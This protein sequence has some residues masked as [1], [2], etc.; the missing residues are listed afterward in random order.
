MS[1]SI[2]KY[3]GPNEA[4]RGLEALVMSRPESQFLYAQFNHVPDPNREKDC[5]FNQ[6]TFLCYK[7]HK[8]RKWNWQILCPFGPQLIL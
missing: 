2:G 3:V 6:Y 1:Q 5:L 8:F 4:L 7:W